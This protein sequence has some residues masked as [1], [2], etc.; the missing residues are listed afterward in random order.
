MPFPR[1]D[2]PGCTRVVTTMGGLVS[3]SEILLDKSVLLG[4]LCPVGEV[5][6]V[7]TGDV[8]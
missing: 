3:A 7:V 8:V 2:V 4:G 1:A 5:G 6:R